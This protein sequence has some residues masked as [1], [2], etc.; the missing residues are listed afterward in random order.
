MIILGSVCFAI[1][2]YTA[3]EMLQN[4]HR[5]NYRSAQFY[6]GCWNIGFGLGFHIFRIIG[7]I[8]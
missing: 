8:S 1:G 3:C 6:L 2:V 4:G 5:Y 7:S